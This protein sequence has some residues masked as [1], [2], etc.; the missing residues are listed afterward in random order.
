MAESCKGNI[1]YMIFFFQIVLQCQ[2][3]KNNLIWLKNVQTWFNRPNYKPT[4]WSKNETGCFP[5]FNVSWNNFAVR[6]CNN[7]T[8]AKAQC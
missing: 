5:I 4:I 7:P 1:E 2:Y 8:S 3:R 6:N